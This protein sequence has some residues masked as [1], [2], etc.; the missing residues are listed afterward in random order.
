MV[1]AAVVAY[2]GIKPPSG[3][4]TPEQRLRYYPITTKQDLLARFVDYIN[5]Q[6]RALIVELVHTGG[7]SELRGFHLKELQREIAVDY[8]LL[9]RLFDDYGIAPGREILDISPRQ[10]MDG[11]IID[12][13]VEELPTAHRNLIWQLGTY[14]RRIKPRRRE[15]SLLQSRS[16]GAIIGA[17]SRYYSLL[18]YCDE[19]GVVPRAKAAIYSYEAMTSG[20][21]DALRRRLHCPVVSLYGTTELGYL[22]W[23]CR[24]EK[25]HFETDQN[26]VEILQIGADRPARPGELGRIIVT[27]L[28]SDLMPL[29]RYDAGDYG[30]VGHGKCKCRHPGLFLERLEGRPSGMIIGRNNRKVSPFRLLDYLDRSGFAD[31]QIVQEQPGHLLVHSTRAATAR[32]KFAFLELLRSDPDLRDNLTCQFK[33]T[34]R[35]VVTPTGKRHPYVCKID[36]EPRVASHEK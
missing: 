1:S 29:V 5:T 28:K 4:R 11:K 33:S 34:G 24:E 26:W 3:A 31:Y 16:F 18:D 30:I 22:G 21:R 32:L 6:H 10:I 17:P 19:S 2:R 35:F 36:P 7:T 13:L 15:Y 8:A 12:P 9:Y 23:T 27:S 20:L 25:L 14:N